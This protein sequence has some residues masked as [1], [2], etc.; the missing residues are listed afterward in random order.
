RILD[1]ARHARKA[2]DGATS[3]HTLSQVKDGSAQ[4]DALVYRGFVSATGMEQLERVP[5]YLRA[6]THRMQHLTD[7]LGRDRTWQNDVERV[8]EV[9]ERAGGTLPIL[10]TAPPSLPQAR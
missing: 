5:V 6:L 9:Y 4:L 10:A 8:L 2:I 7:N 1:E 3:L